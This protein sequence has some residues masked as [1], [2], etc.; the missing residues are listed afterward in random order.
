MLLKVKV[1]TRILFI[2][3]LLAEVLHT[4]PIEPSCT[5]SICD[6][7]AALLSLPTRSAPAVTWDVRVKEKGETDERGEASSRRGHR[8]GE[9]QRG[10]GVTGRRGR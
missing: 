1:I 10:A 7:L 3:L 2:E 8:D 6:H 5:I 4:L 9:L